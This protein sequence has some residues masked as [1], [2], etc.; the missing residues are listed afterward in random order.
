MLQI[1]KKYHLLEKPE[2][3]F[4]VT[5]LKIAAYPRASAYIACNAR[6]TPLAPFVVFHS[7]PVDGSRLSAYSLPEFK[8][9]MFFNAKG[10]HDGDALFV[11][12]RDHFVRCKTIYHGKTSYHGHSVIL[13][14]GCPVS[15]ISLRLVQLAEEEGVALVSLPSTIAH[16]VQPLSS[17]ILRSLNAAISAGIEQLLIDGKLARSTT[18]SHSLLAMLLAEI[19]ANKWPCDDVREAFASC[20]I[21]PL[22]VR[23]ISAEHI[24]AASSDNVSDSYTTNESGED[25]DD[26]VTHGLNLLSELS[27]LEQQ[28]ET[29]TEQ[30]IAEDSQRPYENVKLNVSEVVDG[31][32][33]YTSASADSLHN[34]LQQQKPKVCRKVLKCVI[35]ET[36]SHAYAGMSSSVVCQ[37]YICTSG[38]D[39]DQFDHTQSSIII[40]EKHNVHGSRRLIRPVDRV[41]LS[42]YTGSVT[43]QNDCHK[44]CDYCENSMALNTWHKNVATGI[45]IKVV[46]AELT[47]LCVDVDE[48]REKPTSI[49][50]SDDYSVPVC[51][52]HQ[53][54]VHNSNVDAP[55]QAVCCPS[56]SSSVPINTEQDDGD[57]NRA[58]STQIEVDMSA[59]CDTEDSCQHVCCEVIIY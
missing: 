42:N 51:R 20:G 44:T 52:A 8:D 27:T 4:V 31:A 1:Y 48:V 6:G 39:S 55:L 19:W 3:I 29:C 5:E 7:D 59:E 12:F 33:M 25:A 54:S 13:F 35:D 16:L 15:E 24:A 47:D 56:V 28:K 30:L 57:S 41:K 17:G 18:V 23:A 32:S 37:P 10:T 43:C 11:W 45:G 53:I 36:S 49:N 46:D 40:T 9:A 38:S 2:S 34:F 22:N 26:D 14:A 21:F 58:E 50:E